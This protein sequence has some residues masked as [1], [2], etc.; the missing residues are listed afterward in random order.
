MC[1]SSVGKQM[2]AAC[3]GM[4]VLRGML[5]PDAPVRE[6][7]PELPSWAAPITVRHL[8]HHT[9][10]IPDKPIW[11]IGFGG[12][13]PDWTNEAVIALLTTMPGLQAEPGTTFSCCQGRGPGSRTTLARAGRHGREPHSDVQPWCAACG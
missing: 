7:I 9:S 3:V 12:T 11:D 1:V 6:W 4:P 8:I 2:T 13:V 5:D 10:G